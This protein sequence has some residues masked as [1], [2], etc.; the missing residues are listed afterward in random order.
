MWTAVAIIYVIAAERAGLIP[1][2]KFN[3]FQKMVVMGD[4]SI[5]DDIVQAIGKFVTGHA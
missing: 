4:D 3:G 1:D 5:G 2:N